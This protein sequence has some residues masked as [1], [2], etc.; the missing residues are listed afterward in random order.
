MLEADIIEP[1]AECKDDQDEWMNNDEQ[2]NYISDIC[3]YGQ[4]K[5]I[6]DVDEITNC[7]PL[8]KRQRLVS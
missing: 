2:N 8:I 1:A 6:S 5:A 4:S 3:N 7:K